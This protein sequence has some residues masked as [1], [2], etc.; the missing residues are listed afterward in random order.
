MLVRIELLT[1]GILLYQTVP[2]KNLKT[3]NLQFLSTYH[4]KQFMNN[5]FHIH[6][7]KN[8]TTTSVADPDPGSGI[9]DPVPFRPLDPGSGIWNRFFPDPGSQIPDPKPIFLRTY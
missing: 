2:L 8:K 3:F 4:L 5:S 6:I 9:R 1:Q 7:K